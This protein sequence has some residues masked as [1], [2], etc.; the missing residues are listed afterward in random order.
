MNFFTHIF[1]GFW[2]DFKLFFFSRNRFLEVGF[3]FQWGGFAFQLGGAS[4]LSDGVP[5]KWHRFWWEY[6]KVHLCIV[7]N[8]TENKWVTRAKLGGKTLMS[9]NTVDNQMNKY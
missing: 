5:Y 3:T 2:L 1:Q 4:F 9:E 6:G 7:P 8:V